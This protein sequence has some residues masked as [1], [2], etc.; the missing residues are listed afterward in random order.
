V[1]AE[2]LPK[3]LADNMDAL[4]PILIAH[5]LNFASAILILV[6]GFW[7]AGRAR[8]WTVSGLRRLP[9]MDA[10]LQSFF[11]TIVRYSIIIFTLLA[12]LA[13]F[14]V[15]TTSLIAVLGAAGLA[16]GL[17]LQ[18]TLSNVAAGVMLLVFRPFKAGDYVEVAADGVGGTVVELS[19][20]ST[21]LVTPDNLMIFMPNSEIWST[22]IKNYSRHPRRRLDIICRISYSDDIGKA[23]DVLRSVAEA[24]ARVFAD[25]EPLA[26]VDTLSQSSVD[27]LLRVWTR[28]ADYWPTRFDLTRAI[29][30]RFDSEGISIPF[31]TSTQYTVTLG[32]DA[33]RKTG[34]E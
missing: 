8:K 9:N 14:G 32:E 20:F 13:K 11:G 31:P 18:G 30:E 15:Q 4:L 19:L 29:K 26:V 16:V 22:S 10:T 7:L 17:A 28:N 24:D 5:G 21:E 25:P 6:I 12:V 33:E 2:E 3:K 23:T 27:M 1:T 34:G